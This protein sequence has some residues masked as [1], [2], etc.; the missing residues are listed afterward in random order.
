MCMEG[1]FIIFLMITGCIQ[2]DMNQ[3]FVE[4][5]ESKEW[6]KVFLLFEI[7]TYRICINGSRKWYEV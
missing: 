2:Q 3:Q 6:P 5:K 1:K 4:L 7:V